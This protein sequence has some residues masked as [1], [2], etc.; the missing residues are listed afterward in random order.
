MNG[1]LHY[2]NQ[3]QF[4]TNNTFIK[5]LTI[6]NTIVRIPRMAFAQCTQIQSKLIIP[7]SVEYIDHAAFMGC[8][9]VE[10]LILPDSILRVC[11]HAFAECTLLTGLALSKRMNAIS[12]YSFAN[13][14]NLSDEL[15]IPDSIVL[16]G[17]CAFYNCRRLG[18]NS[19]GNLRLP[20]SILIIGHR[21]FYSCIGLIGDLYFPSSIIDIS[22]SAFEGCHFRRIIL[23]NRTYS[24]KLVD[25]IHKNNELYDT[26]CIKVEISHM[27]VLSIYGETT[28][29]VPLFTDID[30]SFVFIYVFDYLKEN[31]I[32]NQIPNAVYEYL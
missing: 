17:C 9:F 12:N 21:A 30:D 28:N 1:H 2:D 29:I 16:I 26:I 6:G 31:L 13:C 5:S 32:N 19:D 23:E 10:E 15:I 8:N 22:F 7:K 4:Y 18:E 27:L 3:K 20:S 24:Q 25:F 11:E 14:Y